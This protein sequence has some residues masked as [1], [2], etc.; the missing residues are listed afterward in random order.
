MQ[1]HLVLSSVRGETPNLIS[2]SYFAAL[3]ITMRYIM[4]SVVRYCSFKLPSLHP[5]RSHNTVTIQNNHRVLH[6]ILSLPVLSYLICGCHVDENRTDHIPSNIQTLSIIVSY[7]FLQQKCYDLG[8]SI[9]VPMEYSS[10]SWMIA[11]K[12]EHTI[13]AYPHG[14]NHT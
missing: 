1:G 11:R 3:V 14:A 7:I 9:R 13:K 10:A 5:T 12:P 2:Q 4:P 6:L 8:T